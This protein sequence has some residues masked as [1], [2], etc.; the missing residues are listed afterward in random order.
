MLTSTVGTTE[1]YLRR[2]FP[3]FNPRNMTMPREQVIEPNEAKD[4][5]L[6]A[7]TLR[8]FSAS[9]TV[10]LLGA[11]TAKDTETDTDYLDVNSTP[12]ELDVVRGAVRNFEKLAAGW[13]GPDSSPA[14]PGVIDDALEVLQNWVED[15]GTPEPVLAFD[16]SVALELYDEKGF[17]RGGVEFKGNHRAIYTVISETEVLRSGTF[18]ASSPS[19]IIRSI[20]SIRRALLS[21]E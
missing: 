12:T 15:I 1:D 3:G 11:L 18:N 13:D 9:K 20:H 6:P 7:K 19:E 8:T 5:H 14:L 21:E 4:I 2:Q 10:R 16:G 17:T